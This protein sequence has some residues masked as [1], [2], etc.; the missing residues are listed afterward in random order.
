MFVAPWYYISQ[1]AT[2]THRASKLEIHMV[3]P[4]VGHCWQ[5]MCYA[6]VPYD[7]TAW[8]VMSHPPD[9]DGCLDRDGR[10][11]GDFYRTWLLKQFLHFFLHVT[12]RLTLAFIIMKFKIKF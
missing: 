12:H 1:S 2:I 11:E 7:V 9:R 3:F 6:Y 4:I 10:P 5:A 8:S